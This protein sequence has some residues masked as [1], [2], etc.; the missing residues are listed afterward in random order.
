M[1]SF[2]GNLGSALGE[3]GTQI[4]NLPSNIYSQSGIGDIASGLQ[5]LFG[6]EQATV[7][8]V[9]PFVGPSSP[10]APPPGAFVGPPSPYAPPNFAQ[11]LV[12]GFTGQNVGG[13]A[14]VLPPGAQTAGGLGELVAMLD[15]IRQQSGGN[16]AAPVSLSAPQGGPTG[17]QILPGYHAAQAPSGGLIH[18]LIGAFTYGIL[19]GQIP[20]GGQV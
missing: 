11:A 13:G 9:E 10:Y 18:N 20:T 8:T 2:G 14:D 3:A 7:P 12:R 17:V 16:M 5:S 19:G 1:G 4:A 6:G 15:K